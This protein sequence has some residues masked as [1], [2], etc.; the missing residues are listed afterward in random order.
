ME[1][2]HC[3]PGHGFIILLLVIC[4]SSISCFASKINGSYDARD[5]KIHSDRKR[6]LSGSSSGQSPRSDKGQ[7]LCAL[8][9]PTKSGKLFSPFCLE[10]YVI[11]EIKF[12]DYGQPTGSCETFKHGKCGAKDTL[13][14]VE[15]V[16][17]KHQ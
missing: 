16:N 4:L 15:K 5:T 8:H 3:L 2:T 9:N 13:S 1:S 11:T 12:A 10:G 6:S 14:L 7:P 17:L